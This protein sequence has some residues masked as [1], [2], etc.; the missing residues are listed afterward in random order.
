L[1]AGSARRGTLGDTRMHE[2]RDYDLEGEA[3]YAELATELRA[4]LGDERDPIANTANFAALLFHALPD[5]NWVG[6]YFLKDGEL[7]L[8]PFQG[9]PA[10]IRIALGRGVCGTAA[11]QRRTQLVRDVHEFPGHIACDAR[12][13]SEVVVPLLSGDTLLGVLDLDSPTVGRFSEVDRR[14]L[15]ELARILLERTELGEAAGNLRRVV[16][17]RPGR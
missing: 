15:E 8:G 7:V 6:F 16:D 17:A 10:C 9:R 11:A 1:H 14:G 3:L 5:V 12:S 4:M 2:T 13:R